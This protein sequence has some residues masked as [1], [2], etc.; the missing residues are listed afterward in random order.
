MKTKDFINKYFNKYINVNGLQDWIQL[1]YFQL[2]IFN[3]ILIILVLLRTAGYFEPIFLISINMIV[4]VGLILSILILSARSNFI[5]IM[6]VIFLSW[7]LILYIL[8]LKIWAERATVYFFESLLLGILI[9][10]IE[11]ILSDKKDVK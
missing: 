9:L 6:S 1:H 5:F 10:I 4:F 7:A 8:N 2:A 3:I 11:R